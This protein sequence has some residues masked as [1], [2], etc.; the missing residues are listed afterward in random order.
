MYVRAL[1]LTV[2]F[3]AYMCKFIHTHIHALV[4]IYRVCKIRMRTHIILELTV[5]MML[6]LG[7]FLRCEAALGFVILLHGGSILSPQALA[8][9]ASTQ[10]Y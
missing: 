7:L 8:H 5:V 6:F 4:N 9:L 2:L 1:C 10:Y 3:H